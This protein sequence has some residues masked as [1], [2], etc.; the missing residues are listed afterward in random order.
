MPNWTKYDYLCTNCD[1]LIEVT[2]E[3]LNIM[4]PDCI[5]G[6][7]AVIR[8][9]VSP[10]NAPIIVDPWADEMRIETVEELDY[11]EKY[12]GIAIDCLDVMKVTPTEVVKI[13]SN[14]YN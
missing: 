11:F 14:P 12:A 10:G 1:S 8:I 5:C 9:G 4:D 3:V 6:N 7:G 13:N 2:A